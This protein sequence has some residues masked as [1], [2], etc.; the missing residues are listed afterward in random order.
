VSHPRNLDAE[1]ALVSLRLAYLCRRLR[2]PPSGRDPTLRD[3]RELLPPVSRPARSRVRGDNP[4]ESARVIQIVALQ[5]QRVAEP[6]RVPS[7]RAARRSA[8]ATCPRQTESFYRPVELVG[9]AAQSFDQTIGR[10]ADVTGDRLESAINV[11]P[12]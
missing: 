9:L 3:H 5:G 6:V 2:A 7:C 11:A 4:D 10:H 8:G 12:P 1:L